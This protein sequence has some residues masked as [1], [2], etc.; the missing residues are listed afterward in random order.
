MPKVILYVKDWILYL[1]ACRGLRM[2]RDQDVISA[3]KDGGNIDNALEKVGAAY[4][5]CRLG[6]RLFKE[7]LGLAKV[8]G[9]S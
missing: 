4:N 3:L 1:H 7:C 2:L 6:K 9:E 5:T 8:K